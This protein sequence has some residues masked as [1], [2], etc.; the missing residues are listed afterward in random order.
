MCSKVRRVRCAPAWIHPSCWVHR[1]SLNDPRILTNC[2]GYS[3]DSRFDV[4]QLDNLRQFATLLGQRDD[5]R[6][7]DAARITNGAPAWNPSP[8]Q[9][10]ARHCC[11]QTAPRARACSGDQTRTGGRRRTGSYPYACVSPLRNTAAR[12]CGGPVRGRGSGTAPPMAAGSSAAREMVSTVRIRHARQKTRLP[13]QRFFCAWW[14]ARPA[15]SSRH[16]HHA[17]RGLPQRHPGIA[18]HAQPR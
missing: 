8:A 2:D 12:T 1:T 17:C 16:P 13:L 9:W 7:C 6:L 5:D 4:K 3:P 15:P 10:L 14:K 18:E 11:V